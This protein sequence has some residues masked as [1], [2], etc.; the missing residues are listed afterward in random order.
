MIKQLSNKY[1][2][3]SAPVKASLWF[4]VCGFLQ[5]G[6]SM[7]TT[8][9]YTRI[10]TDTEYGRNSIYTS[11]YNI[12]FVIISFELAAGVYTK[13]LVQNEDD[14]DA[15]SSSLLSLSTVSVLLFA[16][17]YFIFRNPIN[18]L[19]GM[20]TYL[21]TFMFIDIW[22]TIAYQFWSNRERVEYRYKKLVALIVAFTV[23]RPTAGVIAVLLAE[24]GYQVEA[25]VSAVALVNIFLFSGLYVSIIKKG[26]VFLHKI[27]WKHALAFNL[28]LIPHYL[29]QILLNQA[30]RIMI[31]YMCG[32]AY[33]A[34]YSVAYSLAMVMQIFNSSVSST[35]NPWIY[36]S[37]KNKEYDKIG[38]ISYIIL[39]LIAGVNFIMV[40]LGPELLK[41]MAPNSY[42]VALWV[43]PP[44]TSS[45]YFMFLYNLFATFEYYFGKTKW[46]MYASVIG[47]GA[48][49]LLNAI[50]IPMFG[51]I[52]AGYTTL[53]CYIIYSV[54]HYLFMCKTLKLHLNGYRI[55]DIKKILLVA[56]TFLIMTALMLLLYKYFII[57]YA[58]I[59]LLIAVTLLYRRKIMAIFSELKGK[60]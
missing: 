36:R 7:L 23:L 47:A 2:Q 53:V 46:V 8:P 48:N 28:P 35:M 10:M 20:S 42:G 1:K 33:A 41:I 25:R 56:V 30:D 34:Y 44:V 37:I 16:G 43:I 31:S 27:Y 13:G 58:V 17:V 55:Y 4:L 12:L 21:M 50:F 32:E 57:R 22:T 11:W 49:I 26:K 3:L 14:A 54:M 59:L 51:F 39:I 45:V 15:Y 9:I 40:A 5:K 38:N 18:E 52:A 60:Q 6:M 19:L 29:S 24:E